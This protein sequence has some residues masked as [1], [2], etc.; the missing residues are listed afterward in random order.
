[1]DGLSFSSPLRVGGRLSSRPDLAIL[2]K[3]SNPAPEPLLVIRLALDQ[4][5]CTF[6]HRFFTPH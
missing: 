1:M 5:R 4:R 6:V 3:S 2:T